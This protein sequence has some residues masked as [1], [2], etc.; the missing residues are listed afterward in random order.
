MEKL[1]YSII[2]IFCVSM[3]S[4]SQDIIVKQDGEELNAN[5]IEI[6]ENKVKYRLF[7]SQDG[8]IRNLVKSDVF[9]IIYE[10]GTREKVANSKEQTANENN[11]ND[12]IS[13]EETKA[14]IIEYINKYGYEEDSFKSHYKAA[15]EGDYLRL[16]ELKKKSS[17]E[18]NEG[19]LYDFAHVYKFQSVSRR[20]DELAYVNIWVTI[21]KNE[22]K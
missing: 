12:N 4:Y 22:K 15:F 11:S 2:T 16:I 3:Y 17:E 20:S 5:V 13:L 10:N 14:F 6:T 9:M 7:D 21:L 18:K 19:I 1:I 8:P